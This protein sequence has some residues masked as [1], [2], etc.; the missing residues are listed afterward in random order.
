[1]SQP[2]QD[3]HSADLLAQRS[4]YNATVRDATRNVWASK[5]PGDDEYTV[6]DHL[7]AV[8]GGEI[9]V[10][11]VVPTPKDIEERFPLLFWT[12]GGGWFAGDLDSNDYP[13]RML[14]H[15]F[16]LS[17][18][19]V[20]YRLAPEHRHPT[21]VNDSYAALKWAA[22]NTNLLQADLKKGF[23]VAG[24]SSGGHIAAI[25]VQ[26]ARDD[27]FFKDH[28][29]TG[30]LLQIPPLLHPDAVERV[31]EKLRVR[32]RSYEENKN[33]ATLTSE[34]M[35]F[36]WSLLLGE[37]N[38]HPPSDPEVSPFLHPN[39]SGLPPAVIQIAEADP[40]RDEA[41]LY[42]ELLAEAGVKARVITYPGVPHGFSTFF[43][44]HEQSV[45]LSLASES[46]SLVLP[47]TVD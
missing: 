2:K 5:L 45:R 23:I 11:A 36:Y 17:V 28:P 18:V 35:R 26:R 9:L 25:L 30:Q 19:N 42:G 37:S 16:R 27:P 22:A 20:D 1:M 10:R 39:L 38:S 14:S 21:Q 41:I 4:A 43:P 32:L 3:F 33:A 8:E 31:S 12:H 13:L 24:E 34:S 29:I 15:Q 44:D 7:V 47:L 6:I 40:L 46:L